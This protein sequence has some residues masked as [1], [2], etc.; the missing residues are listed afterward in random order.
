MESSIAFGFVPDEKDSITKGKIER[1]C[2]RHKLN[3]EQIYSDKEEMLRKMK[4]GTSIIFDKIR[5][6]G[7]DHHD[8]IKTYEEIIAEKGGH[9]SI[10]EFKIYTA[11]QKYSTCC[12]K[13]TSNVGIMFQMTSAVIEAVDTLIDSDE[14]Q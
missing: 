9:I 3:L 10:R 5:H 4:W 14:E 7:V 6:V 12:K 11:N 13:R 2:K 8:R 1:H